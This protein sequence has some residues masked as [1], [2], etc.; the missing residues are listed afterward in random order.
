MKKLCS[1]FVVDERIYWTFGVNFLTIF[2]KLQPTG[3][4]EVF[5]VFLERRVIVWLFSVSER[6]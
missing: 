4:A 2:L 6:K 3:A 1:S 5:D